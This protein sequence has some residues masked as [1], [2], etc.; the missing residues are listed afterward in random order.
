MTPSPFIADFFIVGAPRCGTTSLS[1]YLRAHPQ[2]C[3]SSPKETFFFTENEDPRPE[4]LDGRYREAFFP[5]YDSSI[6]ESIGEG[7]V[8][9]L[10][11]P[12]SLQN[13]LRFNPNARFIAM[14]RNPLEMLPSFHARMRYV[15]EEDVDRFSEAWQLQAERAAG[16][17]IPPR[18]THP[19]VLQYEQIG[20]LGAHVET[21]FEI[22]GRER[23]HVIVHDDFA[24]DP[25]LA[26]ERVLKFLELSPLELPEYGR[27]Q[28]LKGYRSERLQRLLWKPPGPASRVAR[29]SSAGFVKSTIR[30]ARKKLVHWNRASASAEEL[31]PAFREELRETFRS[32]VELLG[33]L[34]E[35]DL[36]HWS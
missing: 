24:M 26:Y 25:R 16:K 35:R 17:R 30:R 8:H 22:A 29:S 1:K 36:S 32:D 28:P 21:L 4:D 10:F 15:L 6:H 13:I 27:H 2:V 5:H 18:C 11:A 7:S 19:M 12:Y 31:D 20:R 33:N 9:Y 14:V 34:I 3:F 23:C